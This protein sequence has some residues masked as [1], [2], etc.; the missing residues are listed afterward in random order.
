MGR[1]NGFVVYLV[2]EG[3]TEFGTETG[4]L[5]MGRRSCFGVYLVAKGGTDFGRVT[6]LLQIMEVEWLWFVFSG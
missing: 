6:G 4:L 5:R 2:A 3:G 1:Q